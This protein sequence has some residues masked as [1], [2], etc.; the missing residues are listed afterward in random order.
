VLLLVQGATSTLR[1]LKG[2]KNLGVL[3]SPNAHG[4]PAV[5]LS[6][7]YRM[8]VDNNCFSGFDEPA[9]LRLLDLIVGYP[10]LW[11]TAPDKV[12]DAVVTLALF[13]H[14]EPILHA[15][16]FPVALV[17]QDGLTPE[18]VPW[19]RI[20]CLFIG[21]TDNW[22]LCDEAVA[23]CREAKRRGKLVHV[24]RCNSFVRIRAAMAMGAD[25]TDGSQFSWWPDRYI[26]KGLRWIQRA[27]R[28]L[29][30]GTCMFGGCPTEGAIIAGRRKYRPGPLGQKRGSP[31]AAET[32]LFDGE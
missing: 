14:W 19:D 13:E 4:T 17:A 32:S 30:E 23:L 24:G 26:P 8:A 29:G 18:Q 25:S 21:G 20:E 11:V 16:G 28:E 31:N 2:A 27:T 6:L 22:K 9:Y 15:R 10:V 3:L 7:G 1:R 5:L 12:G